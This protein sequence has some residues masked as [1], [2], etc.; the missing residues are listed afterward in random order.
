LVF[1]L[2]TTMTWL[3]AAAF[4]IPAMLNRMKDREAQR[5]RRF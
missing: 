3:V 2:L 4:L 1:F 5:R